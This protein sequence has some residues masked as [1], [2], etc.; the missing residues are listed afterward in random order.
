MI[1]KKSKPITVMQGLVLYWMAL[2]LIAL[3]GVVAF[4]VFDLNIIISEQGIG[5]TYSDEVF[6]IIFGEPDHKAI[7][8]DFIFLEP[9]APPG[10]RVL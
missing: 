6:D 10:S 7:E 3:W 5:Y 1:S 4:E 8:K 2:V 9:V